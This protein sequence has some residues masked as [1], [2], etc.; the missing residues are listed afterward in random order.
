VPIAATSDQSPGSRR[1]WLTWPLV[2]AL[3][4]F[5]GT[6]VHQLFYFQ[7]IL[8]DTG[9]YLRYAL[10]G[11]DLKLMPYGDPELAMEYP[12]VAYWTMT[13]PRRLAT[14]PVTRFEIERRLEQQ[15]LEDYFRDFHYLMFGVDVCCLLL[16]IAILHRRRVELLGWGACGYVLVTGLLPHLLYDRLDLGVL[17]ALLV[18]GYAWLRREGSRVEWLWQA[19]A[20]VALGLG[21]AYKLIP[22]LVAP[23]ALVSDARRVRG[24]REAGRLAAVGSAFV[25]AAVL[26]FAYYYVR[27]GIGILHV[28]EYHG[29]RGLEIESL[30][31]S[32][33]LALAPL[34]LAPAATYGFGSWNLESSIS[35]LLLT[36]SSVLVFGSLGSIGL[37]TC[38]TRRKLDLGTTYQVGLLTVVVSLVLAKVLSPQYLIWG[39]VC[40]MM[41]GAELLPRRQFIG[42]VTLLTLIA[43]LTTCIFPYLF[44]P[45]FC[46][47]DFGNA[48]AL[49]PK[50]PGDVNSGLN[51]LPCAL[52]VVRNSLFAGTTIWLGLRLFRWPTATAD[53]TLAG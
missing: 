31:A 3:L 18:W 40:L 1:A 13:I 53:S 44:V 41:L 8:P 11:V 20:Y 22:L 15:A 5:A 36:A 4:A 48:H 24:L 19:I 39:L 42:L 46:A 21:F 43:G 34:G 47:T 25:A 50:F 28:F 12:P 29:Q 27:A 6:R 38:F 49:A 2:L 37:W 10:H 35:P 51:W 52:I 45:G 26:P 32:V 23:I 30:Y 14:K 17:L 16:V 9:V 33:M 7:A